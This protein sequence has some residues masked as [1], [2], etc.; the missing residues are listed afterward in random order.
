[1]KYL[2]S[3]ILRR[4]RRGGRP[5]QL[6]SILRGT[7]YVK[8]GLA[9]ALGLAAGLLY[10]R[11][12]AAPLTFEGLSERVADSIASRIGPGWNVVLKDSAFAL[13]EGSVAL[14]TAGLEV[15][16]PDGHLVLR[17]PAAVVSID[18]KSLLTGTLQPRAIE[19]R[20]L[21]VRAALNRDGSLSFVAAEGSEPQAVTS[22]PA[23]GVPDQGSGSPPDSSSVVALAL[24]SLFDL[25]LEPRG[26]VG[27]LDRARVTNARLAL[28]DAS[29][30]E[31]AAFSQVTGTFERTASGG[32]R[33]DFSLEGPRGRWQL[34]GDL[35]GG[36]RHRGG[37]IAVA[38]VPLA[39]LMLLSGLSNAPATTDLKLSG[40]AA[41]FISEGRLASFETQLTTDAGMVQIDDKDMPPID[42]AAASAHGLW[43]EARRTFALDAVAFKSAGTDIRLQAEIGAAPNGG[44]QLSVTGRDAVVR[45]PEPGEP[46]FAIDTI[47]ARAR[48]GDG[49]LVLEQLKLVGPTLDVA[50]EGTYGSAAD[51]KALSV[52]GQA[53]KTAARTALRLWP[54]AVVP[55]VR[56]Y[57]V[58]NLRGGSADLID[59]AVALSGADLANA[60]GDGPIP[61]S[62]VKVAF[63]VSGAEL[64]I[65]D[66]LPPV[67]AL[68]ASG[69]ATGTKAEVRAPSARV[70]MPEGRVLD[71]LDGTFDVP[72]VWSKEA[73]AAIALRLEGGADALG[74]LLNSPLLQGVSGVDL[75]PAGIKGRAALRVGLNLP[76]KKVPRMDD[77]PLRISGRIGDLSIEKAF[78]KERLDGANLDLRY[79]NGSVAMKG[80]GR[81]W[82]VPASIE[83]RQ[84]KAV[85]GEAFVSF[86]LDDAARARKGISFGQQLTGPVPV[87]VALPLGPNAKAG[88]KVEV[89]LTRAVIDNLVPGWVKPTGRP[90]KLSFVV[91]EGSTEL[92]EFVLDSGTVQMRGAVTLS[93]EGQL[94]KADL[95]SFKL[96]PGDDMRVQLERGGGTYKVAVRGPV[97]D[98]R[99]FIRSLTSPGSGKEAKETKDSRDVDLDVSTN[100]LTGFNDEALTAA[101]FKATIRHQEMKQF[102]FS[103]KLR[104]A[105]VTAQ[106]ARVE[107]GAPV[108]VLESGDAGATLRFVD[109]YRRM[110]GGALSVQVTTGEGPQR[111]VVT[112]DGFTLRNEPALKRIASTQA[113]AAMP[114]DRATSMQI[115]RFDISEVEFTRLRAE[116]GRTASRVEFRDGVV[117][118]SQVGFK[119]AGWIDYG[120]DRA[121]ISG[122]FV[123]AYGLN[124]AFAQVPLFGPIL[125]GGKN[126]GLFA[127]NFR[128]SG[129]ASQPT[130]TVNPLSAVAPGFLRKLF[131][132]GSGEMDATGATLLPPVRTER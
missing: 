8:L 91:P 75:D 69:L 28:V 65:A 101:T 100:I 78:G 62:A 68:A 103:G 9:A 47:E 29:G 85:A 122:T 111:G 76:L 123:P 113:Q 45:G 3:T 131:G 51:P 90:G 50:L 21:Q 6:G 114:E 32:R 41:A 80:E 96:S 87:K 82:G 35:K 20:D 110:H 63:A 38:D 55:K 17:S 92:R 84:P 77:L 49:A 27:A 74:A 33:F 16:N 58:A 83:V 130:L 43:D 48:G 64:K 57:L 126:E 53:R 40:H 88:A 66:G 30:R 24:G 121:D 71:V 59:V 23:G 106:L 105:P 81:L 46:P 115:P 26:V 1:M 19:F 56:A 39:D 116:F 11:L 127:V 54:N 95:T 109:L 72:D 42:V 107:R 37:S 15:R 129:L 102:Q 124:N 98:A 73:P 52:K 117:Y 93:A 86:V 118:G 119:G 18:A 125:G 44:W 104:S 94:E 14:R 13:E 108:L 67:S 7:L 61:D 5:S 120:R 4:I 10:L 36:T 2:P 99:P 12:S 34:N 128:I 97:A 22:P 60:V 89:D 79:A 70:Q 132:T 25:V 112:I 31:R